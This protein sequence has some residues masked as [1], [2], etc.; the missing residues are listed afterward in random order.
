MADEF[1]YLVKISVIGNSN[2]GKTN[3]I[4]RFLHNT[5]DLETK[6]TIGVDFGNKIMHIDNHVIK[7]QIWDTAGQ[8]RYMA[9]TNTFYKNAKG[10]I[11]VYDISDKNSFNKVNNWMESINTNASS[12]TKILLLGNKADLYHK[13][14]VSYIEGRELSEKHKIHLFAEISALENVQRDQ[15]ITINNAFTQLVNLILN[16]IKLNNIKKNMS[17]NKSQNE[18]LNKSQNK[19]LNKSQNVK[20]LITSE[21][22]REKVNCC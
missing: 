13:R 12:D 17:L 16:D 14:Q 19:S 1:D 15:T 20:I 22:K 3:I 7:L 6:S 8:E 18:S 11:V 5:F 21:I 9:I 4:K 10:I 2:V